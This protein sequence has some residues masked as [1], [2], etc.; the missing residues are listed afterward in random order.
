MGEEIPYS[1][2]VVVDEIKERNKNLTYIRARILTTQDRYK[3]MIIGS[4][5]RKIKEMGGMA[6]KEIELATNKKVFLDLS[7][8]VDAHWQEVLY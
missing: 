2:T 6:R 5:G 1:V 4:G 3:R 8:E 7:V